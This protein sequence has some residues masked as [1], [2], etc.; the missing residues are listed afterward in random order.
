MKFQDKKPAEIGWK[1][2]DE[3]AFVNYDLAQ[4]NK[5]MIVGQRSGVL[6]I[7]I[8]F[9]HPEAEKFWVDHELELS[10]GVV[11][12]TGNGKHHHCLQ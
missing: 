8:D 6:T 12:N 10:C 5:G 4:I 9:K 11:V 1:D 7:D 3:H 2:C